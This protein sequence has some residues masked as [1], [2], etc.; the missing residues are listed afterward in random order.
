MNSEI[1]Q[2][3]F[4]KRIHF[5]EFAFDLLIMYEEIRIEPMIYVHQIYYVNWLIKSSKDN[6]ASQNYF[7]VEGLPKN[8]RKKI[9]DII[10]II[11]TREEI[12]VL[13]THPI[14]SSILTQEKEP[15]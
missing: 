9:E 12:L 4:H 3:T 15:I 7:Q 10:I 6:L 2:G 8:R 13:G 5:A 1:P 11:N 14:V